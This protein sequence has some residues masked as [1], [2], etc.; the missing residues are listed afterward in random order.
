MKKDELGTRM[1]RYESQTTSIKLI[2]RLPIIARL[3]GRSFSKFTKGLE[4]PYD[5][6]LSNLMID[7]AKYLSKEFNTNLSYTQSDEITLI[8]YTDDINSN[9]L[10]DGKVFKLE[11]SFAT[12]ATAFFNKHLNEYLPERGGYLPTFDC[13]VFNVP[14]LEEAVNC[15]LWREMDA[16]KNSITMAASE[17]YSHKQLHKKNGSEKQEMLFMKGVNWNDYPDFFKKGS[18]IQRKRVIR[19]FTHEELSKLPKK[20]KAFNNP[21]LKVERWEIRVVD[22]PPLNKINNKVDVIIYGKDPI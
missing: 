6:R 21:D 17:Y 8:F 22:L 2:P 14:T 7:T 16:T 1:K 19:K 13:R 9:Q 11:T 18:Y 12:S 3:D 20:H 10:F 4:R 15:V 5:K